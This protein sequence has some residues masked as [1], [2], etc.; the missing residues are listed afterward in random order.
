MK[1]WI[2]YP[3]IGVILA[4]LVIWGFSYFKDQTNGGFTIESIMQ[5]GG[6]HICTFEKSDDTS[7]ISGTI[8]I[9]EKRLYGEFKIKTSLLKNDFESFLIEKDG[10]AYTWTSLQ[11]IGYKSSPPKQDQIFN[12]KDKLQYQCGPWPNPDDTLFETPTNI[13]FIELKS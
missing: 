5:T 12:T 1:D 8:H 4:L 7:Q 10:T 13:K 6:Y 9:N 3:A 2:I 11:N